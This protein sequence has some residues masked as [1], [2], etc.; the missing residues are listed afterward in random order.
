MQTP[1]SDAKLTNTLLI[2]NVFEINEARE[3]CLLFMYL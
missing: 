2:K 1:R 3:L